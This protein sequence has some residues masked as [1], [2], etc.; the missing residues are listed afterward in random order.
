MKDNEKLLLRIMIWIFFAILFLFFPFFA[1]NKFIVHVAIVGLSFAV[2]AA[3]WDLLFGY[4][5]QISFGHA[6][7]YG[8]GA[9]TSAL[10]AHHIGVSPW[11]GLFLG[12]FAAAILGALIGIPSLRIRGIYLALTT[13]AFAEVIRIIATN[14][15]SVTRGTLGLSAK[16]YPGIEFHTT[17]YYYLMLTL[18][19]ISV[20][21]MFWIANYSKVGLIFR[22]I[23]ADEIRCQSLG[24]DILRYKLIAFAISGFFAGLAGAFSAHY[25]R[26]I[27]PGDLAPHI[28]I[29]AVAM[30]VIGGTSTI[31]GPAL[32]A[33]IIHGLMEYLKVLGAVYSL[34]AV[35]AVLILF[36]IFLPS[37]IAGHMPRKWIGL[38]ETK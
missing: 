32:A 38:P 15:H 33:I 34:M 21:I 19:V 22:A 26:L 27:N 11:I 12:S 30:A 14:W 31:I 18:S 37:G 29:F 1:P 24:I 6:G 20:G 35:G 4:A 2:L 13:L 5:G 3:S 17:N 23:K 16:P 28:T 8:V 10:L 9:Y 25:L 7:F 36:V